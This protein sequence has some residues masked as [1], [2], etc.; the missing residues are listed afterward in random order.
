MSARQRQRVQLLQ[1]MR[2]RPRLGNLVAINSRENSLKRNPET[3]AAVVTSTPWLQPR[4]RL[5]PQNWLQMKG[6][7]TAIQRVVLRV[8][9]R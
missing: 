1:G 9:N 3:A 6:T 8:E 2:S 4:V 5:P 7:Q